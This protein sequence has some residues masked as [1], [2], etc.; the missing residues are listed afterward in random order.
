MYLI[1]ESYEIPALKIANEILKIKTTTKL[2]FNK[3]IDLLELNN[4]CYYIQNTLP[5]IE[6]NLIK[7]YAIRI[8]EIMEN[9][10]VRVIDKNKRTINYYELINGTYVTQNSINIKEEER[11]N[12][13]SNLIDKDIT[14]PYLSAQNDAIYT[15][16]NDDE[17]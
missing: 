15:F 4:K 14:L 11:Y 8:A 7:Y 6:T 13:I 2:N 16:P 17:D 5:E 1:I 9:N 12:G 3:Y 10:I